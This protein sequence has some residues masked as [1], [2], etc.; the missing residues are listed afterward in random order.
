[1]IKCLAAAMLL[2]ASFPVAAVNPRITTPLPTELND[3]R[4]F[5]ASK[6][7]KCAAGFNSAWASSDI[8]YPR[9][10]VPAEGV[11][12][13]R[14]WNVKAWRGERLNAQALL[15]TTSGA[16]NVEA[17]VSDLRGPRGAVI[18]A[19]DVETGFLH[20]VM[21][22]GLGKDTNGTC[23]FRNKEDYDSL[24]VADVIDNRKVTDIAPESVQ[25]VWVSVNVPF[26]AVP[27]TY[28]GTLQWKGA[29][30]KP[31]EIAVTVVNRTLPKAHDRNFWLDLWQHPYS[32]ARYYNVPLWSE[33]H[34]N[35][36]RDTYEPLAAMGQKC[37]T[38]TLNHRPWGG[39][40]EDEYMS[41]I[42]TVKELDGSWSHNFE[43]FDKYVEF[44]LSLGIDREINC[45][46]MI[47]WALTFPYF[48]RASNTVKTINAEVGSPEFRDYWVPFLKDFS[49][50]LREKGWFG[51]TTI[52]MDERGLDAMQKGLQV[53]YEADPEFRISLAGNYHPEIEPE[54]DDYCL[55]LNQN[56]TPE[57][58]ERRH[59]N[60]QHSTVYTCC[61]QAY[62]NTYTFSSPAE[63]TW[64]P[65]FAAAENFD[66]YLRWAY[67]S[68]NAEPL[69]D[70]RFRTWGAGDCFLMYPGGR[71][72]VRMEKLNEGI[73]DF[74]KIMIL[75]EEAAGD[76]K[77]LARINRLLEGFE[78][79]DIPSNPPAQWLPA[80]RAMLNNF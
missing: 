39:Q 61:A 40:C 7:Q 43:V 77:K 15:W 51:I 13:S 62:P 78:S 31:L 37:V 25:P 30:F 2:A 72:S 80:R 18:P 49:K 16:S 70:T 50:H 33:E 24:M 42:G 22:D 19:A 34:F 58:L 27:G 68:W 53:I 35:A 20:Y 12:K 52:A 66:G 32:V 55:A 11:A 73:Q 54:I 79:E 10:E 21:T 71:P 14:V 41:M 29:P 67:N 48:D 6:W 46:S 23:G 26:D 17:E 9:K 36:M 1:M 4:P 8:L 74:E 69:Q 76:K 57:E 5:D 56:F 64:L 28:R 47:P 65:W 45:Y 38:A 59:K 75:R 3:N 44:M 60:G 63:A